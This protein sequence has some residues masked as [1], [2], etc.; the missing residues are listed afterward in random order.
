MTPA[1]S[2][3]GY[4]GLKSNFGPAGAKNFKGNIAGHKYAQLPT[5]SPEQL[6]FF[7]ALLSQAQPGTSQGIDFLS[8]LSGGDQSQFEQLESPYYSA[9]DR[10]GAQLGSR[11]SGL[12]MGGQQS[13]G[14][15][16][17]LAGQAKDLSELLG[18]QRMQLQQ[19]AIR[20]LLGLSQ[21]LLGTPTF[22]NFLT[23]P[24]QK[25][26]GFLDCL[27]MG[28]GRGLNFFN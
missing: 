6:N 18:S 21:S 16:N 8:K 7:Q 20:E 9:L 22:Q 15:Q 28:I 12:G 3:S 26:P 2:L 24:K 11:F 5:M 1:T 23:P 17:A 13:S 4:S 25:S 27:G 14:F 19:N 10:A